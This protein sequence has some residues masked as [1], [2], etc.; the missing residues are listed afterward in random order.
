LSD[1]S[2]LFILLLYFRLQIS[3][4]VDLFA[5]SN[6][7]AI[8]PLTDIHDIIYILKD[9]FFVWSWRPLKTADSPLPWLQRLFIGLAEKKCV[10]F[11]LGSLKS[12]VL[13]DAFESCSDEINANFILMLDILTGDES[14]DSSGN[15]YPRKLS[16][17]S[18]S[19]KHKLPSLFAYSKIYLFVKVF[20]QLYDRACRVP[21]LFY[22]ISNGIQKATESMWLWNLS[23]NLS[24]SAQLLPPISLNSYSSSLDLSSLESSR[25]ES[26]FTL[27]SDNSEL[28]D[29]NADILSELIPYSLAYNTSEKVVKGAAALL[30][31]VL[32][33]IP[34]VISFKI[35]VLM[36]QN[37]IKLDKFIHF[38]G[39]QRTLRL[40]DFRAFIIENA[41][42][43]IFLERTHPLAVRRSHILEDSYRALSSPLE[44]SRNLKNRLQINFINDQGILESGID[45]GGLF[46]EFIDLFFKY[47]FNEENGKYY[48]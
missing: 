11:P 32:I 37:Y 10:S 48:T 23:A 43:P 7:S 17:N 25:F 12:H 27:F 47:I 21:K 28:V 22:F 40:V 3:D 41:G 30:K 6:S 31:T 8:L 29:T 20:N 18:I 36:F 44:A 35:R 46:K 9:V 4:D 24:D 13:V 16:Y 15:E 34:Q 39:N 1:I 2:Y 14:L 5:S 26:D 45:G 38:Y 42:N 19:G 33:M